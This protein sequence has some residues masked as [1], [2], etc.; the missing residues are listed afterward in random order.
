MVAI[1]GNTGAGKSTL[2]KLIAGMYR[3]QAGSFSIDNLD[4]RQLNTMDLRRAISYVPQITSMFHGSI[5]Q[6]MRLNNI[7]A[8]D[9]D[10]HKAA[11]EAGVL[12]DILALPEGFDTRIGDN[13]S[14]HLPPGFLRALSM[15]RAFVNPAK[16]LLLDEPGASLD[17]ESDQ[18]L[19]KQ[20]KKLKRSH[21]IIM[22]SHRP[23]HIRI[24]DK[25]VMMEHGVVSFVGETDKVIDMMLENIS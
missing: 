14:D 19:I 24:A 10:L 16:I 15:A 25:A 6:N 20:L 3:P 12:D 23:S 7:L 11:E 21:T 13:T 2:I 8:T 17:D 22:I 9:K 4:I 18:R 1:C 5:A